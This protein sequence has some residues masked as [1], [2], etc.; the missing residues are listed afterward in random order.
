M[1][2]LY[3]KIQLLKFK[4]TDSYHILWITGDLVS[5]KLLYGNKQLY[6]VS[7]RSIKV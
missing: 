3:Y 1:N 7:V 2:Y 4:F 5:W 6:H